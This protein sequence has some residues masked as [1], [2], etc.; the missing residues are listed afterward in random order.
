MFK[1]DHISSWKS[2]NDT[3]KDIEEMAK[4]AAS[5]GSGEYVNQ[6]TG[7]VIE[8]AIVSYAAA[9]LSVSKA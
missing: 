7:E 4:A 5:K 2:A 3:L 6:E 1:F 9:S 8:P